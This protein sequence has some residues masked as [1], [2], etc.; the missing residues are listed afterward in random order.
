[1]L[2]DRLLD[3]SFTG[4]DR[5]AAQ[6]ALG[7]Y[8]TYLEEMGVSPE[9]YT[10]VSRLQPGQT[11]ALDEVNAVQLRVLT[12]DEVGTPWELV[13]LGRGLAARSTKNVAGESAWLACLERDKSFHVLR[14]FRSDQFGPT[15]TIERG[16]E[17]GS[18]NDFPLAE[19][20]RSAEEMQ[21]DEFGRPLEI[22][23]RIAEYYIPDGPGD[24]ADFVG[25]FGDAD[26]GEMYDFEIAKSVVAEIIESSEVMFYGDGGRVSHGYYISL[27]WR[28]EAG[29]TDDFMEILTKNCVR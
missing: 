11:L 3:R 1:M 17:G 26:W 7:T 6:A 16:A 22:F 15:G 2:V 24:P 20:L 27:S 29:Q 10:V 13:V 8:I 23:S 9:L 19:F 14:G 28:A 21:K 12:S 5:L 4:D 25:A 18:V